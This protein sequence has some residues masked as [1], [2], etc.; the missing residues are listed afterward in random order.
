M[1]TLTLS[2]HLLTLVRDYGHNKAVAW[3][4]GSDE[5]AKPD[6]D[7]CSFL[8]RHDVEF[9]HLTES[10]RDV[11]R[12]LYLE[13]IKLTFA[14][15]LASTVSGHGDASYVD[16]AGDK[17]CPDCGRTGAHFCDGG[18]PSHP[19]WASAGNSSTP[20]HPSPEKSVV[21]PTQSDLERLVDECKHA[22]T[23]SLTALER[24]QPNGGP[25]GKYMAFHVSATSTARYLVSKLN[26]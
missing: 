20:L 19:G 7:L 26:A 22:L 12:D 18:Q 17:W 14:Q 21:Q 16:I 10:D 4:E 24:S 2:P 13:T 1:K 6:D 9:D 8:S 3:L 23:D 25:Y 5:L 11:L 15:R